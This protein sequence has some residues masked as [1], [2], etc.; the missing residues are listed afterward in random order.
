MRVSLVQLAAN[1]FGMAVVFALTLFLAAG[2]LAWPA[3]WAYLVLMFGFTIGISLWL[4]RHN[5]ELLAERLSGVGRADQKLW[6][7]LLLGFIGL[8]FFGWLALMPLDAVR[9]GWSHL[10]PWLQVLGGLL[11]LGSFW[12]FFLVFRENSYLSP[13]VRIQTERGQTVVSSGP[14]RVV[15][16]PMYAAVIP[17]ALGTALLLGSCYG[18]LGALLL[19]LAIARRAVLEERTLTSE[20]PGYAEYLAKVRYRFVP[21]VW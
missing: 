20:L 3:G 12:L 17:F 1:I 9:F 18:L 5:P 14:Y 10:P 16:H 15:R 13:A 19:M 6:D 4:L 2:T 8:L 11:M 7:K 21:R